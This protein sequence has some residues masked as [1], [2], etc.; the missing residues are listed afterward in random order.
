MVRL[1]P[2]FLSASRLLLKRGENASSNYHS[3]FGFWGRWGLLRT[4]PLGLRRRR[5]Y[6]PGYGVAD[7]ADRLYVR[8]LSLKLKS[9]CSHLPKPR[10]QQTGWVE[11]HRFM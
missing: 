1:Q 2:L 9:L 11:T 4:Q 10:E 7:C 6:R 8:G 5:G 3:N